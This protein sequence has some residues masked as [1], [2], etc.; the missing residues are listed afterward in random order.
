MKKRFTLIELL[1]VIAI[2]AIL[3]A[4]LLPALQ[5]ARARAQSA[6]CINN[7][8]QLGTMA[9]QYINEHKGW[10][11]SGNSG[12]PYN[13]TWTYL[14]GLHR[15]KYIRLEETNESK[16]W[17]VPAGER[18]TKL[19]RSIPSFL[20]C[21]SV[22]IVTD[23]KGD[24][25][26]QAYGSNYNNGNVPLAVLPSNHT[27]LTQG[28]TMD[29]TRVVR[30]NV[31][32]SDRA[33]VVDCVNRNNIHSSQAIL[34]NAGAGGGGATN[35]YAYPSPVHNGRVN[36]LTYGCNVASS[37]PESLPDFFYTRH[38]SKDGKYGHFQSRMIRSYME[39]GGGTNGAINE[40]IPLIEY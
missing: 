6:S 29:A 21:P 13:F 2:I 24:P 11:C 38:V 31:G 5:S 33:M 26:A 22:P 39:Q 1:V 23:Y 15:G 7:L 25:F 28:W 30:D 14:Y 16:W 32:P 10:W 37:A 20:Q 18:L 40:Y 35:C 3:A 17:D 4:I 12:N 27:E 8:K 9:Q 34:W 19:I 36:I